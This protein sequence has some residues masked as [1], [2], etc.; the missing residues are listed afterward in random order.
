MK[1]FHYFIEGNMFK[2]GLLSGS[3]KGAV[4]QDAY[5]KILI[6]ILIQDVYKRQGMPGTIRASP[7]LL[8]L[9]LCI[10]ISIGILWRGLLC[11]RNDTRT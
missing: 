4:V 1:I 2:V 7:L 10:N 11:R 3:H 8:Q 6:G 5:P 9:K